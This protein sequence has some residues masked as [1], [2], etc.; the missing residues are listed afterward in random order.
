M[1]HPRRLRGAV[2][3]LLICA[4]AFVPLA[5]SGDGPRSS[6]DQA[7]VVTDREPTTVPATAPE[8][9]TS[10]APVSTTSAASASAT[11]PASYSVVGSER[12]D[13]VDTSRPTVSDGTTISSTRSLPSLVWR[14]AEAGRY[15]LVVFAHGFI[16][17]P[18]NYARFCEELAR[19]GFVVVAP[20]F[21]LGDAGRGN[22]LDRG[23]IPN[24][25]TD[26]GFV[27]TSVLSGPLGSTIDT[28]KVGVVGHSDGA[29]DVLLAGYQS[30][31]ADPRIG[32]VVAIAPDAMESPV[33][34]A[35]PPLLLIHADSDTVVPYSESQTVFGQ[36]GARRYF[37]T[38]YGADHL[39][40]MLGGN[41]WTPVVDSA[42]VLFLRATLEDS[43]AASLRDALDALDSSGLT[44]AG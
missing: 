5:C 21:P 10:V 7:A 16:L 17:G 19:S 35:N 37:L 18:L 41:R 32:A 25:A 30:G 28:G 12:L 20:S 36:I 29:D 40:P 24:Q 31:R 8:P 23:D 3:V 13:L 6:A 22:P 4:I 2:V 39:P 26:I 1:E 42:V 44:T 43:G 33:V 38:L 14:P 9:T 34:V 15:P 27:I 11:A